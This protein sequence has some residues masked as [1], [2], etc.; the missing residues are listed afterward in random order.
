MSGGFDT[1]RWRDETFEL[2]DQR[3][4]PAECSYLTFDSA[5]GVADAIRSMVVR[6]APAIGCTAAYG[7][8]LEARRLQQHSRAAFDAGMER[9]FET[10]ATSRP[11]AV[12]LFWALERMRAHLN[13]MQGLR[14]TVIADALLAHAHEITAEDV[15]LNRMMGMHG[16]A[17]L[18][19][20]ARVLTHCNAGALAT[21][22]HGTALGIIRSAVQ[23]GKR[24]QVLADETRPFLQGARLTA[25]EL[26]RDAIPVTLIADNAA[27]FLMSR[28]EVDA[29]IVGADRV[30]ANGDV[31]NKVGTYPVAVLARRHNVPFYVAC[32]LST[33]DRQVACGAD[34][35]IEERSA[36]EV[37]GYGGLRWAPPD[38][39]VRNPVFDVTPAD[40]VTALITEKGI[41]LAP[42]RRKIAALFEG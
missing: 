26:Q 18:H 28:G 19:D 33:I 1:L 36:Q 11:T 10:L 12:N 17:L 13:E 14:T 7:V 5:Q 24:I 25:W 30:A 21:A 32:P 20:G 27:G 22:G 37:T 34:I 2:L 9:A 41:T 29:V 6:G 16:S 3:A 38:I 4:L 8:A 39:P 15:R 31:A 40:L 42:D 23:T 35:P